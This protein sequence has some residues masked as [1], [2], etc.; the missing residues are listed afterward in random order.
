MR[1]TSDKETCPQHLLFPTLSPE[2]HCGTPQRCG[3]TP[4]PDKWE[5]P[6]PRHP[7]YQNSRVGDVR[8][9]FGAWRRQ[10]QNIAASLQAVRNEQCGL[11]GWRGAILQSVG[12]LAQERRCSA[13]SSAFVL[14]ELARLVI[15]VG[16][17]PPLIGCNAGVGLYRCDAPHHPP[18]IW[19][20]AYRGGPPSGAGCLWGRPRSRAWCARRAS[21]WRGLAPLDRE[22]V[23][24]GSLG[25]QVGS[26]IKTSWGCRKAARGHPSQSVAVASAFCAAHDT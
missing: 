20:S 22:A 6:N 7:R 3:W 24:L 14:G 12:S 23:D 19:P 11:A 25:G 9:A 16:W 2:A 26:P 1:P 18:R 17:W 15:S 8:G 5:L 10:L 4:R 21:Q 13:S